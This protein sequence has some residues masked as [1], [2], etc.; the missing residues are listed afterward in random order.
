MLN[1]P[2]LK[3]LRFI[4]AQINIAGGE[5]SRWENLPFPDNYGL[6]GKQRILPPEFQ[7]HSVRQNRQVSEFRD[8]IIIL[9]HWSDLYGHES[10][11]IRHATIIIH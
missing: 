4:L 5:P 7:M 6:V 8:Y 10:V 3:T 2:F 9:D 1:G 11:Q